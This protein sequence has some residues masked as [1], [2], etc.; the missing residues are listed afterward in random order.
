V[1]SER[2]RKPRSGS[3]P[4][5]GEGG[6]QGIVGDPA[7]R[8]PRSRLSVTETQ[9]KSKGAISY[10]VTSFLADLRLSG[11][12]RVLGAL[13]LSLAESM[14]KAPPYARAKIARELRE[15]VNQLGEAELNPA[16]L[17]LLE[18]VEL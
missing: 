5:D 15:V 2:V 11:S 10:A 16:N 3:Q 6:H 14:E 7:L 1:G 8:S 18:G 12:E 9:E 17:S 13:A 4:R